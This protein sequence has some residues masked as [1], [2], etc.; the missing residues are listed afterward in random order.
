MYPP[1]VARDKKALILA[2][3]LLIVIVLL[4]L[5]YPVP[6]PES[7]QGNDR[8]GLAF[9][10]PPDD[11]ADEARYEGA[12]A[13]GARWDRWPL[14][15]HWVAEGG[16][17]GAHQGGEHDYDRLVTEEIERGL[18]PLVILMGTPSDQAK[19]IDDFEALSRTQVDLPLRV[20]PLEVSAATLPPTSLDEPIFLDG[21]DEI[22]PGK[23]INPANAWA[24]FVSTTVERYR[25]GG[26][27]AKE[28]G[29]AGQAGI[30]HWEIWN[31]P[32]FAQFWAGTVQDYYRLLEVA[33]KSIKT[34]DPEATI[35]LGGLAFYEQPN[36][37]GQLLQQ[38]GGDPSRLFFD[39]LSV[40]HY[41]S[42]YN[43][44][45]RL[46]DVRAAL[47]AYSLTDIP[48]WMTESGLSV[49]DDDPAT[50]HAVSPDT[51][52]RGTM[53]EQAAYVI[54]HAALTLYH[55]TERYFHFMLHDDCGDGPS[56]AFGLRQ[57]FSPH[58]CNPA[59]GRP[60]PA[61]RAYQLAAQHFKNLIPLWRRRTVAQDQV[62]FYRPANRS[63]VVVGWSTQGITAAT[64]IT[65]T[66]STAHL[67][68]LEAQSAS[69]AG[70]SDQ[71]ISLTP[72]AGHYQLTL[73]PATNRN[74]ADPFDTRYHIGGR[75]YILVERDTQLPE[76]TV[77]NLFPIGPA[78]YLV[79]WR[80]D[81]AG[82]GVAAYD[83]WVSEDDA[84]LKRWLT[85]TSETQAEF[86]G[87][88]G[89]V[90][91]FAVNARDRAGNEAPP[92]TEAQTSTQTIVSTSVA[93]VVLG[94]NREPV[95]NATVTIDGIDIQREVVTASDGVWPT[96]L[97]A[98]GAYSLSAIAPGYSAWPAPAP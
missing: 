41:W 44:E 7:D 13:T 76:A 3:A 56:T 80:G 46:L 33:Y 36:W 52:W 48:I 8:F 55:G 43:S 1:I 78:T 97:V 18:K 84:P 67:Y 69:D 15:W 66:G 50:T 63:R 26:V 93:G 23:Q 89:R 95:S 2:I 22:G 25:P 40:H 29:W 49:W 64:T 73:P 17:A 12:V 38:T 71:V 20:N 68:W 81:D 28:Q 96:A 94:P 59:Q 42:I 83:V 45:A 35:L 86:T 51:P 62:A 19:L 65:A 14:Y 30:S 21:T 24:V 31:E 87:E 75:P 37:L 61:Y 47:D 54:Q 79:K 9:I 6:L 74:S 16:Y 58:V 11:L 70:E 90:Y 4:W 5:F 82:S 10:S 91:G 27:L 98:T 88:A 57:N 77:A 39:A 34:V 53:D 32:D 85:G 60:R 92:P 72:E